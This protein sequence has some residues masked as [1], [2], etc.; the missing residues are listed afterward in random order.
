MH[1]RHLFSSRL[2]GSLLLGSL[3]VASSFST[4]AAE[5]MLRKAVGKGAYEMAYSQQENAL[6][7][8]TSQSRKLDK[9]GVVYRL[10]PVTLEVTQAIHNDLK[11]FGATINNTTQTLWFGNTVNSA[12]TAID[13]KTG[14]VKGRL[15]LDDRKR[16]EEVRPLQPRELV[17][18]DATNTVYIS[19]IGKES[20][21]WVVDGENIKLKTAIQ[22]TG[23]MS[24][25]LALDS[26]GKRLYTT[27]ADGELITIDTADNKILSRKKLLDDGKEHFFINISLDTT[28]QRAFITDSKAAEV[29]VVD[30]R[31]GNILAKVAAPESLAVLFNPARNEAYVTHRQAGKVSVIDAKSYKV[32]KTFDT[33]THPNSLALSADGK[34]LYV[35]VKQKS[36]KQQEA[37][38]PDDVI[39]IA[40]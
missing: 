14:E 11:P 40:L 16:T 27:N 22:N 37:T 34:T 24:T 28:R 10:D 7:L 3:L 15:V 31:N 18:D 20:V 36:T 38:Q 2:R 21:I 30:T 19:G 32:V 5:E 25:G 9:G 29:L 33:P 26:K 8:A 23:K 12:V 4:Q 39:R 17:A 1:L 6:W 13:A 35:S